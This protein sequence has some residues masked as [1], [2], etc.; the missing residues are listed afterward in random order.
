MRD[1]PSSGPDPFRTSQIILTETQ[2]RSD[3]GPVS[4]L[5]GPLNEDSSTEGDTSPGQ[6]Q[7]TSGNEVS[8]RRGTPSRPC[9]LRSPKGYPSLESPSRLTTPTGPPALSWVSGPG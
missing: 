5:S 7:S 9:V 4:L 6:V 3:E 2:G 8:F 1:E